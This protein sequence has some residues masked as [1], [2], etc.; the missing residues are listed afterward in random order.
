[1]FGAVR[2]YKVQPGKA[3]EVAEKVR[4]EFLPM[5]EKAPGFV[6]YSLAA[7]G[8]DGVVTTSTFETRQQAED[9]VKMA[10][11]WV[12]E[13]LASLMTGPPRVTTG[14]IVVRHVVEGVNP[15]HGALRRFEGN[16]AK[17]AQNLQRIRE[18]LLP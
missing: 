10:S 16:P 9:S 5:I 18:S 3:D 4:A 7:V 11:D 12:N 15:T 14:E 2:E 13:N 1:M 17:E 6:G 8:P